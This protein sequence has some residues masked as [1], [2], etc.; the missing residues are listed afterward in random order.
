[1]P[2][3]PFCS[4]RLG[5]CARYLVTAEDEQTVVEA[6][7]WA[8]QRGLPAAIISGGTNLV[9]A[10]SGFNGL[11]IRMAQRGVR[12]EKRGP[13]ARLTAMAGEP[14]DPLVERSVRENLAGAECMSG[15]PGLAGATV[16]QNV[17]AYGQEVSTIVASVRVLDRDKMQIREIGAEACAFGYRDSAFKRRPGAAVVLAVTFSL[18]AGGD[19]TLS[20]PELRR[21]LGPGRAAPSLIEVR[22]A[23]MDQRSGKAMLLSTEGEDRYSVGSF[24]V[25]PVV[26]ATQA[27][28]VVSRAL[29]LG[30]ANIA[31]E[32][33]RFA[34]PDNMAKLS[35][36]WLIERAGFPK[37][38]RVGRV[39]ISSR[40]ALA[41]VQDGGA[42]AAELVA[43]ARQVRDAVRARFGIELAAEPAFLGFDQPPL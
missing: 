32:V 10:D 28:Q 16:V 21:A 7:R 9:V 18:K 8:D 3:A 13:I 2:L 39:G 29:K 22:E 12:V 43:F 11:A 30:I 35:A 20:Y 26:S 31:D 41:L 6:L 4:L 15:I 40:H 1:M 23:V 24:F 42:T 17:G 5:G 34:A 37:G 38:Y 19:P 25:N 36:A 33:P 27:D 14:W